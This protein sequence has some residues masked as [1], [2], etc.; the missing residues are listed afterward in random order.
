MLTLRYEESHFYDLATV[1]IERGESFDVVIKGFRARI[2]MKARPLSWL[3]FDNPEQPIRTKRPTI[4][5]LFTMYLLLTPTFWGVRF[6][7]TR[8]HMSESWAEKAGALIVS[9]R[10]QTHQV[11]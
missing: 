5:K 1:A 10:S 8:A 4:L 11:N 3:L 6:L 9:F 7:A 2:I